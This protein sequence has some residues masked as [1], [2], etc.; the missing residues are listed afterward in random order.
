MTE[1]QEL[2][3]F[4][5]INAATG[6]YLLPPLPAEVIGKIA[7][8]ERLDRQ[9]LDELRYYFE[10]KDVKTFGPKAGVNPSKLEEAGWGVIFAHDASPAVREALQPLLKHRQAQAGRF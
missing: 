6:D 1:T 5:G 7:R 9:H 10:Q 8:G 3:V 2:L 4:N